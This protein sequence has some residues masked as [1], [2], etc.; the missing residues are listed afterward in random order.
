MI[1]IHF[2]PEKN[3]KHTEEQV[4]IAHQS[5][6]HP[7][8]TLQH[9]QNHSLHWD[10]P[11]CCSSPRAPDPGLVSPPLQGT[12]S[13]EPARRMLKSPSHLGTDTIKG[14]ITKS[15]C[16][17]GFGGGKCFRGVT[18]RQSKAKGH[19]ETLTF[20]P[21]RHGLQISPPTLPKLSSKSH[22]LEGNFSYRNT[23][24]ISSS[25]ADMS[26]PSPV[27]MLPLTCTHPREF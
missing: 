27:Y 3:K 4:D 7:R 16:M 26:V 18:A 19:T 21:R 11:I 17:A 12:Q 9:Q 14:Q 6:Q 10:C 20:I 13:W 8:S 22:C 23:K 25:P 15:P 2:Y 1:Q 5:L 24:S